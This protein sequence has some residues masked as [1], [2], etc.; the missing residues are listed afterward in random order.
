MKRE[1]IQNSK[2]C[3]DEKVQLEF[4]WKRFITEKVSLGFVLLTF[5]SEETYSNEFKTSFCTSEIFI[6][7]ILYF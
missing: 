1:Q 5:H 4:E 3:H 7:Q 2:F 6:R